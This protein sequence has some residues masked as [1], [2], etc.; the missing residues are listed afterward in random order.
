MN[1]WREP[2]GSGAK[3]RYIVRVRYHDGQKATLQ[4]G[5][6]RAADADAYIL[7]ARRK[8]SLGSLHT[9]KA[10]TFG[11]FVGILAGEKVVLIE[12]PET[13]LGRRKLEVAAETYAT[14]ASIM[15]VHLAHLA[16]IPVDQLSYR[17]LEDAVTTI[18]A[19]HPRTAQK[20]AQK[21]RDILKSAQRRGQPIQVEALNVPTPNHSAKSKGFLTRAQVELLATVPFEKRLDVTGRIIRFASLTGLRIGELVALRHANL[22]LGKSAVIVDLED[23]KTKKHKRRVPLVGEARGLIVTDIGP[24]FPAARGG[25]WGK[26]NFYNR[27]FLPAL[28]A[29]QEADPSFPTITFHDLRH[30]FASWM[31]QTGVHPKVLQTL[32]GHSSI[33]ITMDTYGHLFPGADTDAITV[34]ETWLA[35][36]ADATAQG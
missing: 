12:T 29:A 30:T 9:E 27:Q 20:A 24:L 11:K 36:N 8:A 7:E 4:A 15:R 25:P 21:L 35:G 14:E 5:F 23:T 6:V 13:W 17:L 1:I 33:E 22:A 16:P 2:R 10:E 18:A 32:L 26:Q 34:F 28:R 19:K 3:K 31:I